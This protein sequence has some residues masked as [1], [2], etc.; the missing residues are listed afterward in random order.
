MTATT[1]ECPRDSSPL[2]TGQEYGIEVDRCP[3]CRGAWYDQAELALLEATVA[4]EEDHRRGMIDYAKRESELRCP[5]CSRE[6]RAFNYRAYNLELDACPDEHG[7]WLDVGEA[8]RVRVVMQERVKGLERSVG[9]EAGWRSL[10]RPDSGGV[11]DQLRKLFR[12]R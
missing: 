9:A 10:K 6:M 2:D 12:K 7:F 11:L 1:L 4:G 5:K 8:D 3:T